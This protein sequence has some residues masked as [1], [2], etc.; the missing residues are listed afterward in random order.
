MFFSKIRDNLLRHVE[1]AKPPDYFH[2]SGI[3]NE[4]AEYCIGIVEGYLQSFDE[5]PTAKT[6]VFVGTFRPPFS[7]IARMQLYGKSCPGCGATLSYASLSHP[8][9]PHWEKG[10]FDEPVYKPIQEA[11]EIV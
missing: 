10:C 5:E 1:G 7:T 2:L 4:H 11:G 9:D 8:I 3:G 6:H